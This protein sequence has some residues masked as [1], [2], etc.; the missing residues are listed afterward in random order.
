MIELDTE[1]EPTRWKL[2]FDG[3][4]YVYGCGIRA[5]L[6]SPKGD[7]FPA[8]ARLT[9]PYTN[10]IAEYEACIMGLKMA[11]SMKI[12]E[13]EVFGDS[14]LIIFQTRGE[15]KTKDPKLIPY[16]EYLAKMVKGF[17]EVSFTYVPRT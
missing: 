4:A 10:N 15:F 16:H 9:F 14:S 12:E 8:S 6:V 5:V 11:T 1:L 17:K 2:Y 7:Q 3:A 13:L